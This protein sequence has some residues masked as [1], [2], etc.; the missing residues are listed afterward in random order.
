MQ[1]MLQKEEEVPTLDHA[2]RTNFIALIRVISNAVTL[3]CDKIKEEEKKK[4]EIELPDLSKLKIS[5]EEELPDISALKISDKEEKKEEEEKKKETF[6]EKRKRL[7]DEYR[8]HLAAVRASGISGQSMPIIQLYQRYVR[9]AF[10][11]NGLYMPEKKR[12]NE[13]QRMS[14]AVLVLNEKKDV[15]MKFVD[16]LMSMAGEGIVSD[17]FIQLLLQEY[18]GNHTL[19]TLLMRVSLFE[20]I[21]QEFEAAP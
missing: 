9:Q 19:S 18:R 10:I 20:D 2:V 16:N 15:I 4:K 6:K 21:L 3:A 12:V 13:E 7:R 1:K 5:E 14:F 8:K 17:D 11:E